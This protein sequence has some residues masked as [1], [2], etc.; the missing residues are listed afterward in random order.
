MNSRINCLFSCHRHSELRFWRNFYE[1]FGNRMFRF[2][3]HSRP[4]R[5]S[6]RASQELAVCTTV[7]RGD[8][9]AAA[10]GLREVARRITISQHPAPLL[11]GYY[12]NFL[13]PPRQH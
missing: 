9:S 7:C 12:C 5:P 6:P 1:D 13:N 10:C 8:S 4:A 3:E 2:P 11:M